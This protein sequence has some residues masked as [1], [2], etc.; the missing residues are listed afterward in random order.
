[1]VEVGSGCGIPGEAGCRAHFKTRGV[2][3]EMGD[4]HFQKFVRESMCLS[5]H[6]GMRVIQNPE[7]ENVVDCGFD[8][9]PNDVRKFPCDGLVLE[10]EN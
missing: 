2:V 3:H 1:M 6:R 5:I 7:R 8:P 10:H 9:V 4:D